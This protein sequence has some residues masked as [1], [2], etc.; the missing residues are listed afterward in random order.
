MMSSNI[1]IGYAC[2]NTTLPAP[3][4]TCR[5]QNATP[6]RIVSLARENLNR[7]ERVLHWNAEHGINLFR[8]SSDTVPFGSHEV[9]DLRWWEILQPE[10]ERLG[11]FI[12]EHGMRVS[13]HPGQFTVLNST[14][15]EVVQKSIA[16]LEYHARFLDALGVDFTS[17]IIVHLGGVFG[18][19]PASLERFVENFNLLSESAQG[20]LIVENDEKSYSLA[21][22]LTVSKALTIPV[23][24]DVFHHNWNPSF[25][26]A[27]LTELIDLA[28][29]TWRESDGRPKLHYSNQ[30]LGKPPGAHSQTVEIA[31]FREFFESLNGQVLD[32][33]LETKDKEQSVL[34]IYRA[35]TALAGQCYKSNFQKKRSLT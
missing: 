30:W 27:S 26:G 11:S 5:L 31:A 25:E 17:K 12:R 32:L 3:N 23:V 10:F 13:M 6:E 15:A 21:E 22:A 33:M 34:K 16:E 4:R 20:R 8:I 9:N 19:K 28:M 1:R 2:I 35:I 14:R 7:L 29:Q 18:D 24:F